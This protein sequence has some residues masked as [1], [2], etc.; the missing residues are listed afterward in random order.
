M[1]EALE[2]SSYYPDPEC[3]DLRY[4]IAEKE[5]V[6]MEHVICG[7]GAA[8]LIFHL[9]FAGGCK[10]HYCFRFRLFLEY[11]DAFLA[12]AKGNLMIEKYQ[13]D[14]VSFLIKED[15]LDKMDA[16]VDVLVLCQP[17]NPTGQLVENECNAEDLRSGKGTEYRSFGG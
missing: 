3:G 17:N 11:E 14:P 13:I 7:N 4:S 16:S 15:L 9:A 5:H 2:A 10:K 12:A 1:M 8:E 6:K